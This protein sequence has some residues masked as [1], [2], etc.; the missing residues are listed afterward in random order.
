M[1]N[2]DSDILNKNELKVTETLPYGDS[3]LDE[4][5]NTFIMNAPMKFLIAFKRFD[6][7]LV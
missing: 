1:R 3:S 4:T 6:V 5:N 2:I 7:P